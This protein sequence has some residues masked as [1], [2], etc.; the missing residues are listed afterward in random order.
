MLGFPQIVGNKTPKDNLKELAGQVTSPK[1]TAEE[2][3]SILDELTKIF[4]SKKETYKKT[5]AKLLNKPTTETGDEFESILQLLEEAKD[6]SFAKNGKAQP[7]ILAILP[8]D[9]PYL[10]FIKAYLLSLA[11]N[12][13]LIIKGSTFLGSLYSN[14]KR[15]LGRLGA[16]V[17]IAEIEGRK[18]GAQLNSGSFS[19]VYIA[20]WKKS[21]ENLAEETSIPVVSEQHV[22]T[23]AIVTAEADLDQAAGET[24]E[25]A[26]SFNGQ[27]CSS[28]KGVL[29]QKALYPDFCDKL[30]SR[31]KLWVG[32][33]PPEDPKSTVTKQVDDS[34]EWV[35]YN[36]ISD[37]I[38]EGAGLLSGGSSPDQFFYP[39][40]V[41]EIKP[42]SKYV[43]ED[44]RAP[45]LW[46]AA[47]DDYPDEFLGQIIN[48]KRVVIYGEHA[49]LAG[50]LNATLDWEVINRSE[51]DAVL[52]SQGSNP[53]KWLN[54][55]L[56]QA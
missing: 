23:I 50:R 18:I 1:F 8:F 10:S 48:Q 40:V 36:A 24:I 25:N 21:V 17:D 4:E 45:Y 31:L 44:F 13:A 27:Y 32:P 3:I 47:Y 41:T 52:P 54:S 38:S 29:I 26:F 11:L 42:G 16:H 53:M 12:R 6:T 22:S 7:P 35:L 28:Q 2:K 37:S 19:L 34:D 30:E 9:T 49:T 46:I 51:V 20:G 14:V 39:T 5:S 56:E 43:S 55:T 15:D 33:F